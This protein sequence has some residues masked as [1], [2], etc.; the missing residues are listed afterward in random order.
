MA[1][2]D[3]LNDFWIKRNGH[4]QQSCDEPTEKDGLTKDI[5]PPLTKHDV[6]EIAINLKEC[7]PSRKRTLPQKG[8]GSYVQR[9]VDDAIMHFEKKRERRTALF[10]DVV[11]RGDVGRVKES[12]LQIQNKVTFKNIYK[13]F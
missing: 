10:Y 3:N 4:T 7:S 6:T 11:R 12:L 13:R 2:Y 8:I 5:A 1:G 9:I